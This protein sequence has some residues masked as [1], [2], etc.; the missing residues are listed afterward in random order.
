MASAILARQIA[1][2]DVGI[3]ALNLLRQ[4]L[5]SMGGTPSDASKVKMPDES[6]PEDPS[7]KYF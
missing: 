5:N 4:M 6:D 3:K 7:T 1:G 2:E